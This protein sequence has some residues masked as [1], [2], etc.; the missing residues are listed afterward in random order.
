MGAT[1]RTAVSFVTR[2]HVCVRVTVNKTRHFPPDERHWLNGRVVLAMNEKHSS[3]IIV[4]VEVV[5]MVRVAR[6][7][8]GTPNAQRANVIGECE[9]RVHE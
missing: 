8:L 1:W 2:M 6:N 9:E 4:A 5:M 3:S 7:C